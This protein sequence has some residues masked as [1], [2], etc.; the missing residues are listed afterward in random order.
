MEHWIDWDSTKEQNLRKY[1]LHEDRPR[2]QKTYICA[3]KAATADPRIIEEFMEEMATFK[4]NRKEQQQKL[5]E[6]IRKSLKTNDLFVVIHVHLG[7]F[8]PSY[9]L[10]PQVG[11]TY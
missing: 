9:Y 7:H 5:V 11:W 10:R 4:V 6:E 8:A 2:K 3:Q 1:G